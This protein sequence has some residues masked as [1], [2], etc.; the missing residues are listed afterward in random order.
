MKI[1]KPYI[2]KQVRIVHEKVWKERGRLSAGWGPLD[3]LHPT[4]VA[5]VL[6]L[7]LDY[8]DSLGSHVEHGVHFEV[9]GILNR[10]RRHITVSRAFGPTVQYFTAA[11]EIAHW[12]LHPGEVMHRDRAID[13]PDTQPRSKI[14][15]EAEFFAACL[16]M[17]DKQLTKDFAHRFGTSKLEFN[18]DVVFG[19]RIKDQRR[20]LDPDEDT[21]L[22]ERVVARATQYF[23]NSFQES[24]AQQY[25]VST[26]AMGLQLLELGLVGLATGRGLDHPLAP[27]GGEVLEMQRLAPPTL[28]PSTRESL[29]APPRLSNV[30]LIVMNHAL[31]DTRV[32]IEE[33]IRFGAHVGAF[34]AKPN[35]LVESRVA[36][37][38]K[39]GVK[40]VREPPG[41]KPPYSYFEQSSV[42]GDLIVEQVNAARTERRKLVLIDV[43]GYF[44][45][46]LLERKDIDLSYI[47]GVIEITT[48]GHN[49][50]LEKQRLLPVPVISVARSELKEAEAVYVGQSAVRATEDLL[51]EAG[52]AL[53]G[54]TCLVVGYGMI[55][56]RVALALRERNIRT[57]VHDKSPRKKL[58]AHLEGFETATLE[59]GL[60]QASIVLSSTGG[61]A[62]SVE[63]LRVVKDAVVLLSAGSRTQEFDICGIRRLATHQA[64]LTGLLERVVL[65]WGLQCLI[66]NDG[67]AVNFLKDGTPEEIIDLVF[68]EA[69]ESIRYLVQHQVSAGAVSELPGE[70]RDQIAEIWLAQQRSFASR[71][72]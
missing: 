5:Q 26:K 11:H 1:N 13:F 56:K 30:R 45:K 19:L 62:V 64:R 37:I 60:A 14:E 20:A 2:R 8:V 27:R 42:L 61:Q 32:F 67:K 63:D 29:A 40:I 12:V 46:P 47:A 54:R 15:A 23:G 72:G 68:A 38:S 69:A 39:L 57:I 3:L 49:R 9:A 41:T 43:G 22:R 6:E 28:L 71:V 17:P 24:L 4:F 35:S 25:R 53:T 65:P 70:R 52:W 55:G 59:A 16:V 50:Y 44:C 31:R 18:E 21:F 66:A 7:K 58:L 36:E 33:L 34:V 10:A 48:F 51:Q